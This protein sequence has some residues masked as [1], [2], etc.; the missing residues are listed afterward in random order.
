MNRAKLAASVRR[1]LPEDVQDVQLIEQ[2]RSAVS[3]EDGFLRLLR[4]RLVVQFAGGARSDPFEYYEVDR[5][6]IDAVVI[7]AH[8]VKEGNVCVYLRSALRP[9][10]H[11]RDAAASPV[12]ETSRGI[13]WE[14]PAGLIE[15]RERGMPGVW[16][17]ARRELNEELGFDVPETQLQ[18]LGPPTFPCPGV[19]AERQFFAHVRVRPDEREQPILD[20][21]ALEGCGEVIAL[22]LET[23]LALCATGEIDDGKTELGLRRLQDALERKAP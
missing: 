6:A 4:R 11:F 1:S 22:P 8:F 10:V 3:P 9:P 15:P 17:A 23:A 5:R 16:A 14:L 12:E 13:L 21:S 20:G 19:L 18:E 7:A 2:A